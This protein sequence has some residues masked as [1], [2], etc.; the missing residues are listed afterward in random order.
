MQKVSHLCQKISHLDAEQKRLLLPELLLI[1]HSITD[2]Q[3]WTEELFQVPSA[4]KVLRRDCSLFPGNVWDTWAHQRVP[5]RLTF[6]TQVGR[7]RLAGTQRKML[8]TQ[9]CCLD[10]IR[11]GVSTAEDGMCLGSV[12]PGQRHSGGFDGGGG[13]MSGWREQGRLHDKLRI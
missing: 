5:L 10:G 11:P 9:T 12:W 13:N 2:H 3:S 7:K 8:E 1:L 6:S 4:S